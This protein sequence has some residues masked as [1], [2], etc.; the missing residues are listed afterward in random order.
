M[1]SYWLDLRT[2]GGQARKTRYFFEGKDG[3]REREGVCSLVKNGGWRNYRVI[4]RIKSEIFHGVTLCQ[5][6][7]WLLSSNERSKIVQKAAAFG[8]MQIEF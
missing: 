7:G 4:L 1:D 8:A 2:D 6:D 3:G 5:Q